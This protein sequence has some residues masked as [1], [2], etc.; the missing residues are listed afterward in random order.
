M[1]TFTWNSLQSIDYSTVLVPIRSDPFT[2]WS[3]G[4]RQ[5]HSFLTPLFSPAISVNAHLPPQ[6]L[7]QMGREP[8]PQIPC[9]E[10]IDSPR[11]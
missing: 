8:A 3:S 9:S 7:A 1:P 5:C 2:T 4:L 11:C 6:H 10:P